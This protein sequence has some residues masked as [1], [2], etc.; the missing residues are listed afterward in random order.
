MTPYVPYRT[1]TGMRLAVAMAATVAIAILSACG[2]DPS[3]SLGEAP[4]AFASAYCERALACCT[5]A[6]LA[7]R[8]PDAAPPIADEASCRAYVARVFGNELVAD[9]T[10]AE[11]AGEVRYHGDRMATCIAAI[12]AASCVESARVLALMTLPVACPTPREPLVPDGGDCDHDFQ[13][14]SGL[15]ATPAPE[16]PGMCAAIP[17]A[18]AACT[19]GK[20]GPGGY[21]DRS[22]GGSGTC[23]SLGDLGAPCTSNLGCTE[24]DCAGGTCAAPATCTGT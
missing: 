13:C 9:T 21:C 7:A 22:G 11:A 2:S 3:V 6:E 12:P 15:C 24:L 14:I 19:D 20:C 1:K 17:T 8:F 18:G 5:L 4:A 10:A 23:T 16:T